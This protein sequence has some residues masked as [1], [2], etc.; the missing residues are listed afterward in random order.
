MS[1]DRIVLLARGASDQVVSDVG[2]AQA[3]ISTKWIGRA[4]KRDRVI[5]RADAGGTR[6]S[7]FHALPPNMRYFSGGAASVRAYGYQELGPKDDNGEPLGGQRLLFGSAEYDHRVIG[8]WGVAAFF[9]IGNAIQS[10]SDPLKQGAG[11]GLRW[12]SPVGMMRLD[13]AWPFNDRSHGAQLQFSIGP[14]L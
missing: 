12:A 14:D 2:F 10:F 11:A 13:V 9:D 7:D 3:Q 4:G 5:V 8:N 1:G 6:S